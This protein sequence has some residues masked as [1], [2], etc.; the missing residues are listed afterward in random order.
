MEGRRKMNPNKLIT[1]F[2]IAVVIL[3]GLFV[4]I[5]SPAPQTRSQIV[6]NAF[7]EIKEANNEY[8]N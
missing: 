4:W 7:S 1:V 6:N 2:L 5:Q 3:F 8:R